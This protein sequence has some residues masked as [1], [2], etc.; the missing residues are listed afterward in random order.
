MIITME[1][2]GSGT[3]GDLES[4][5][6]GWKC[7]RDGTVI[8]NK[9]SGPVKILL[10]MYCIE[11]NHKSSET[12]VVAFLINGDQLSIKASTGPFLGPRAAEAE[13]ISSQM[14]AHPCI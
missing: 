7:E 2:R 9:K 8:Q 1:G 13:S 6:T 10:S 11:C 14:Q 4:L 12:T 3:T 5:K